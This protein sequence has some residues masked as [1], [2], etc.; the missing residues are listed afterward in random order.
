V[1]GRV[2]LVE[3]DRAL[4]RVMEVN[5]A[6][7]GYRVDLATDAESALARAMHRPDLI[8]LDLGLPG[9]DGAEVVASVR[10]FSEVPILA[11]LSDIRAAEALRAG[12]DDYLAKP[13]GMDRLVARIRAMER[14]AGLHS[15]AG[16][17]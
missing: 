5:L 17:R 7:R 12:A 11:I 14:A 13:F 10:A 3:D 6:A 15:G 16:A 4:L 1:T 9:R 2:L 8:I